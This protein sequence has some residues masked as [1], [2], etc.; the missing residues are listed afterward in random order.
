MILLSKLLSRVCSYCN[1][2][3]VFRMFGIY[4]P[5][6]LLNTYKCGHV[7]YVPPLYYSDSG[8]NGKSGH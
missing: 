7:H 5:S 3:I 4:Q 8:E 1:V 6:S 2:G